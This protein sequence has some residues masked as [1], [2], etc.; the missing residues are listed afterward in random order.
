MTAQGN[1]L[2]EIEPI[3]GRWIWPF[4]Q[5]EEGDWFTVDNQLRPHGKIMNFAHVTA[6]R[7]GKRFSVTQLDGCYTKVECVGEPE[8]KP[9]VPE[10]V[11]PKFAL[12]LLRRCYDFDPSLLHWT[13]LDE[14][15][16]DEMEAR[17]IE[18]PKFE[19]MV[20]D[21]PAG[22]TRCAGITM[23]PDRVRLEALPAGMTL[24]K[25]LERDRQLLLEG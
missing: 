2:G 24:T 8:A 17:Q 9:D 14:G 5:M 20:V 16:V 4:A 23:L 18:Q 10:T 19:R 13:E 22:M 6:H 3:H 21:L 12:G 1:F 11:E 7:L 15:M 25:W